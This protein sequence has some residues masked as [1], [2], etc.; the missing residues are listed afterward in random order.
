MISAA[1]LS[2]ISWRPP[3]VNCS[4]ESLCCLIKVASTCCDSFSSSS[5]IFSIFL[6]MS[7]VF[8]MRKVESRTSSRDFIAATMSFWI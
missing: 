3:L 6:F 4:T 2:A 7:A 1:S 8:T 5:A